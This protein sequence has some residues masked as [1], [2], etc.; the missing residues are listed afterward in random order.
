MSAKLP[1]TKVAIVDVEGLGLEA[2][3]NASLPLYFVGILTVDEEG[4]V[5]IHKHYIATTAVEQ[6]QQLLSEGYFVGGH[7]FKFDLCTLNTRGL[8]HTIEE[9]IPSMFCTMVM[10]YFRNTGLSSYSLDALTGMKTDVVADA[11][12]KGLITEDLNKSYFWQIDWSRNPEMVKHIGEYCVGDL[13]ATWSL[14]KRQAAWYNLEKNAKFRQALYDLEFPMLSVLAHMEQV[15]MNIDTEALQSLTKDCKD[16]LQFYTHV[17]DKVAAFLPR[18]QWKPEAEEFVPYEHLYKDNKFNAKKG[19]REGVAEDLFKVFRHEANISHYMDFSGVTCA[20]N[21][22]IVGSHCPLYSYNSAAATGHTYWLIKHQ[23]PEVLEKAE[24]TPTGRPKLN[25][26]FF[27]DVADELPETLPIAKF[28]KATKNLQMCTSIAEHVRDG[29]IHGSFNNCLTRTMRLSSSNPNLQNIQRSDDDPFSVGSRFRQL[30]TA[31]DEESTILVADLDRIEIVVLAWYLKVAMK[32]SALAEVCNTPGS[33][34]HQSNA[35]R[36]G[37]SRSVA[38]TLIFL[39]VYG[40]GASL[41]FR[42]G[43]APTLEDSQKMVEEVDRQQPSINKLKA[44]VW[45]KCRERG[46][47]TN[48]FNVRG[49]YPE[50]FSKKKWERGAGERKAFNFLIQNTARCVLHQLAIRS[51]KVIL[52]YGA[53]LVN[54][55][56]DEMIVECRKSVVEPLKAEL[57]AIWGKRTDILKG[58]VINGDWNAGDNWYE[59]K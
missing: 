36:W 5:K 3:W 31:P 23:C 17:M 49:V 58:V 47:I 7:N 12:E 39:L 28:L 26:D 37:V 24:Q 34:P 46:Y 16:S 48:P 18:L 55:V 25:K 27:A 54:I 9:G 42:R 13:K 40:G 19:H 1:L 4:K 56:H 10:E 21:P 30:F 51:L 53:R 45:N 8:Q 52:K 22:Y 6:T 15:G 38:K 35:D 57:Q 43:M 29:R 32:D 20:T 33:D 59:A 41:I 2:R 14:Y 11:K 50:L 44:N